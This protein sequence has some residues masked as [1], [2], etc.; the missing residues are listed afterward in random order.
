MQ[1][2]KLLCGAES[3]QIFNASSKNN[4]FVYKAAFTLRQIDAHD[5]STQLLCFNLKR[6]KFAFTKGNN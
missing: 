6:I 1:N 4:S 5:F 3:L 2:R